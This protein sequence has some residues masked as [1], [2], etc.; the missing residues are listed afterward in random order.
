MIVE[1]A[2]KGVYYLEVDCGENPRAA[3]DYLTHYRSPHMLGIDADYSMSRAYRSQ[4][5]P[6]FIVVDPG[7]IIRFHGFDPD[8][9]LGALRKC[10]QGL[11]DREAATPGSKPVV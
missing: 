6:S 8:R 1:F 11:V 2:P 9:R 10:V 7:G 3:L 5:W 4:G